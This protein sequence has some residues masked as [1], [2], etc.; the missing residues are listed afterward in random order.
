DEKN[1]VLTTFGW[2]EVDWT[3]EFMQWDPK[4]FGGVSRII[5]PPDLIWLPDFGLEN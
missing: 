2:L 5:V 1:Q 4:D 3:D